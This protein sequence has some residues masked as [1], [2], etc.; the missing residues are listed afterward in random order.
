[1]EDISEV[2]SS[3]F[4]TKYIPYLLFSVVLGVLIVGR[5]RESLHV[6]GQRR[7]IRQAQT[8]GVSLDQLYG[9]GAN[10]NRVREVTCYSND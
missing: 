2:H 7:E 5:K 1:M 6:F 4:R 10:P 3:V 8:A 9:N